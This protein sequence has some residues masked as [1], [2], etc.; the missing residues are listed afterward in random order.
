[1]TDP[2]SL[3]GG[4]LLIAWQLKGKRVLIVGGGDVASGRLE[5][6]LVADAYVTL[7][8]PRTGLHPL[9]EKLLAACADRIT[10]HD[11]IF[12]G[13]ED[14]GGIDMVLTAVDD[15]D[16]SRRIAELCRERRIPVNVADD[17][18][19]CDFYFGSQIRDGPLQVLISTNGQSPKLANLIRRRI[20]NALPEEAGAAIEKVGVLR[21]KLRERA[22]GVGGP[23]GKRRMRWMIDVCTAWEMEDLALLDDEMMSRLLDDGWENNRVPSL[24][25]VGGPLRPPKTVNG[26]PAVANAAEPYPTSPVESSSSSSPFLPASLG[27][28][29]GAALTVALYW[30]G[31]QRRF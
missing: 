29:V 15:V 18:P 31:H 9:T 12:G 1:M 23:L 22:P 28:T 13:A 17:P 7:I 5:S 10:Y 19:A 25:E 6:V 14:L 26:A 24:D 27:F 21:A 20:E 16:A 2:S 11:R 4:S 8:S 3:S 30:Y